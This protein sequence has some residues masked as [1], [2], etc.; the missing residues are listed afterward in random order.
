MTTPGKR[1]TT[2]R[3]KV[4][5][6]LASNQLKRA[7]RTGRSVPESWNSQDFYQ[8]RTYMDPIAPFPP[9][10]TLITPAADTHRR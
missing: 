6:S 4:N 5:S 3:C 2:R 9:L 1:V 8:E 7:D 10:P